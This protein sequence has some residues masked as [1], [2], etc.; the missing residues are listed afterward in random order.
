MPLVGNLLS[1]GEGMMELQKGT[2]IKL[3]SSSRQGRG[4]EVVRPT[5]TNIQR[6]GGARE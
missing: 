4:A 1:G 2:Q 3:F 5:T 6:R